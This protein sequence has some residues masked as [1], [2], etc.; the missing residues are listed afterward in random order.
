MATVAHY[1]YSHYNPPI[2]EEEKHQL[3]EDESDEKSD[4]W[5]TE[6]AFGAQT[7]LAR[8]PH[9]VP[10]IISYDEINDL[11]GSRDIAQQKI[12]AEEDRKQDVSGWY[13]SLTRGSTT[14]A[15][16]ATTTGT[17]T[18]LSSRVQTPLDAPSPPQSMTK[19]KHIL[20]KNHWFI[21]RALLNEPSS[22]LMAPPPT[23]A[24]ILSREPPAASKELALR[25]PVFL[26]LGPSN[27]GFAMLERS[28][29]SEGEAL[30]PHA[31]RRDRVFTED[32]EEKKVKTKKRTKQEDGELVIR[33]EQQEVSYGSD[34]EV[35]EL[36][37]VEVVDLTLS[38][39]DD[40]EEDVDMQPDPVAGPSS[41]DLQPSF[42]HDGTALLT[43]IPTI[44][45]SDRLGIGLKAKTEGPYRTSKKRVTHNQAALAAHIRT[46]EEM[47]R[48]KKALGRGSRAFA[49]AAK[50][51]SEQRQRL[52]A[53]LNDPV[54]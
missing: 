1:I 14:P 28:G 5:Q 21:R 43:P 6:S 40:G 45:K 34:G 11:I 2:P 27:R 48:M 4:L 23:L 10:A 51:E 15:S 32:L 38:D 22:V 24:D 35:S 9:F 42:S 47:K 50:A 12:S 41:S 7:R 25:P 46:T 36:K 54:P 20:T 17:S 44:L 18:T 13:R 39:S 52:L 29:W 37:R 33:E 30:G 26:A 8:A 16:G 53:S 31:I 19:P 49:R 3:P